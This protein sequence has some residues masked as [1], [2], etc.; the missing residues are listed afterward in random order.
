[1]MNAIVKTAAGPGNVVTMDV[2]VPMPK[3]DELLVEIKA[4]GVCGTD[5]LLYEWTYKGRSP[6]VP[7]IVLGHEGAGEVVGMGAQ[8]QGFSVG[9]RVGLEALIG[10]GHCYYCGQGL[11]HMCRDWAHLGISFDGTFAKYATIPA[12][13]AHHLPDE[14][15]Y[16]EGAFLE[17]IAVIAHSLERLEVQPGDTAA[18]VGPGP[19]GLFHIQA[20]RAAGVER[21]VAVGQAGDDVRLEVAAKVGADTVINSAETDP[22]EAV[23]SLTGG[24]GADIVVEAGGTPRAVSNAILMARG[25]GQ[26]VMVGFARES[27]ISPLDVVRNDLRIYG[28]VGGLP[29]HT[30]RALRWLQTGQVRAEPIIT[31]RMTL[32]GGDEALRLMRDRVAAKVLFMPN[33]QEGQE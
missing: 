20:L 27:T 31:H 16:L 25:S 4:T 21:V 5:V 6:V 33:G 22:L 30:K 23:R 26:V 11:T 13:A 1:M 29:R 12:L 9:D 32:D 19:L 28:I 10:C 8:V 24:L 18:V 15:S 7:P 17:P 14:V 3:P 2:P